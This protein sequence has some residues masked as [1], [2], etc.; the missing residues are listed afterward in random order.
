MTTPCTPGPLSLWLL[1]ALLA[2]TLLT[3]VAQ[4]EDV[5]LLSWNDLWPDGE[6]EIIAA[7]YEEYMEELFTNPVPEGSAEDVMGPQIGTFNVV[8]DLDGLRV[9][10]PGYAVPFD[11]RPGGVVSEFLLVPYAGACLHAPPPPPNQTVFAAAAQEGD[12]VQLPGLYEA[13]W[14]QGVIRTQTATSDLADA[15]YTISI[16][17]VEP[18]QW[19]Y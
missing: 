5:Q 17:S 18:Y 3:P 12:T 14:L 9:R 15:A 4:A 8:E 1:A 6:D 2:L 13:I 19:E 16:E 7:L 10:I 11:F